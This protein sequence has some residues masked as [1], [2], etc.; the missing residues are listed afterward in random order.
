[1]HRPAS[2][3]VPR[4][5]VSTARCR[6]HAC[7]IRIE[8]EKLSDEITGSYQALY[9]LNRYTA[10]TASPMACRPVSRQATLPNR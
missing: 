9:A 5:P 3:S 7:A 2:N 4:R 10:Y 6:S 1:M 8:E